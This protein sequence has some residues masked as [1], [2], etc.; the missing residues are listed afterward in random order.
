MELLISLFIYFAMAAALY[1]CACN[2]IACFRGH[3]RELADKCLIFG[4]VLFVIISGIRYK[5]GMDCESYAEAYSDVL[6]GRQIQSEAFKETIEPGFQFIT[7][8]FAL[9][10]LPRFV[11]MGFWAFLEFFFFFKALRRRIYLVPF[12]ALILIL[13]PF[14]ISWMNGI[15]QSLAACMFI[16]ALSELVD[17]NAWAKYLV[18]ILIASLFHTSALI[19]LPLVFLRFYSY[20]PNKYI[21]LALLAVSFIIGHMSDVSDFLQH[22]D[23][24][25]G[26]LGYDKYAE[27]I[28]YYLGV[29]TAITS[30]GP[31]RIVLLLSHA[32]VI[33]FSD[34]LF[35]KYKKDRLLR[36]SYLLFL[37]YSFF[38]EILFSSPLL[39]MRPF[40]YCLPF[41]IICQAYTLKFLNGNYK[42]F[43]VSRRYY[44]KMPESAVK[45][46][47]ICA[48][49]IFCSYLIIE[50]IASVNDPSSAV[51]Y[52]T[53]FGKNL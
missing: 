6:H 13:G 41:V 9:F 26:L 43:H 15:R 16:F 53:Y 30:Y 17:S 25:L 29:E 34:E 14:Y 37:V 8:L 33:I 11:Y 50:N 3:N 47:L 10:S 35:H 39:F 52:K 19:L 23:A 31:R 40:L 45:V 1:M 49:S 42:Y 12:A 38:S 32:L 36:V 51:L 5:V 18:L 22:S 20:E 27:N 4:A 28:D 46:I 48:L 24:I 44:I 7:N 21:C 2:S